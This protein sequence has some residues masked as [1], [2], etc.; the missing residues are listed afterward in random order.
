MWL[1]DLIFK[2]SLRGGRYK[3]CGWEERKYL[4]PSLTSV[5]VETLYINLLNLYSPLLGSYFYFHFIMVWKLK[6]KEVKYSSL[7]NT[8]NLVKQQCQVRPKSLQS[9]CFFFP[10][11]ELYTGRPLDPE[12][13][14]S[15]WYTSY[16]Y[17]VT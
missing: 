9:H 13:K 17:F 3:H 10:V 7:V 1:S 8:F 15:A 11:A 5:L 6:F 14:A 4:G 16:W 12:I 2:T